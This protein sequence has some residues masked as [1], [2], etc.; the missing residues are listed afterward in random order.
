W[1][2]EPF[3]R[4]CKRNLGLNGYQVRSQKS[5]TRYLIIMLVAYTYSKLCSGVALSFNTGFKKIQNNLRK[6]QVINIYNA[7]IQ[8]EPINKIF[9]YLKIA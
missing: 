7:A 3:F 2:I 1:I 4:D 5:I 8:G 6:T 9:E